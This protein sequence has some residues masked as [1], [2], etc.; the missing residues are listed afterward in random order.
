[1]TGPCR[2]KRHVEVKL[3][4]KLVESG[5]TACCDLLM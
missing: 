2:W 4:D 5:K 1:M 3:D